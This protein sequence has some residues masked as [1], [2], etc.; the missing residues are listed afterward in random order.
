MRRSISM[1][2]VSELKNMS[3]I[4]YEEKG[5]FPKYSVVRES[6]PTKGYGASYSL[7]ADGERKGEIIDIPDGLI[8]GGA[9]VKKCTE[10]NIPKEG[11]CVGDEYVD[12]CVFH[13][14]EEGHIY[15]AVK[16]LTDSMGEVYALKE[17]THDNIVSGVKGSAEKEYRTGSVNIT[18]ADIG[19]GNV[20]NKSGSDI[21]GELTKAEVVKALGYTPPEQDTDT[22]YT[23]A[24]SLTEGL[25]S[26]ND[27]KKLDGIEAGAQK[28][29]VSGV[30]GSA[31]N[32]YRT[33]SVN[34]TAANIGLGNV[35]NKSGSDI[36][37]ELTKSEVV[38]AL[39][40]TPPE[41]DTK[42][43]V[44]GS[45]SSVSE[46]PVQN[47][48][49]SNALSDGTV[50]K[51][52]KVNVGGETQGMY[53]QGGTPK[54]G[55]AYIP[56]MGAVTQGSDWDNYNTTGIWHCSYNDKTKDTHYPPVIAWGTLVVLAYTSPSLQLY[57]SSGTYPGQPV[58]S[59][60]IGGEWGVFGRDAFLRRI[61]IAK[62]DSAEEWRSIGSGAVYCNYTIGTIPNPPS[63]WGMLLNL[64]EGA[65]DVAQL[66]IPVGPDNSSS[67][68]VRH[69][70]VSRGWDSGWKAL[71]W[72]EH[73]HGLE[74]GDITGILPISKGGTGAATTGEVRKALGIPVTD[75]GYKAGSVVN[76]PS[77]EAYGV[78][79]VF[80]KNNDVS[81]DNNIVVGSDNETADS[82]IAIFGTKNTVDYD[83]C[84]VVGEDNYSGSSYSVT[85]GKGNNVSESCNTA[86]G[87]YLYI[88]NSAYINLFGRYNLSDSTTRDDMFIV[89]NG[90]GDDA[91]SNA[92]RLGRTGSLSIMGNYNSNGA[93]YAEYFE[94]LDGN[95]ENEDR[96]GL[97][98]TL[99]GEKIRI[100][101]PSDDYILGV[102][103]AVPSIVGNTQSEVWKNRYMTDIFGAKLTETV[104]LESSE[105]DGS[106][107]KITETR[108][109]TNPEYDNTQTYIRREDRVEWSPVGML[110]M[111]VAVDDGSCE[112]NG[113][114]R[115][116][117]N[118]IAAKSEEKTKYRVMSRLDDNHVR[119]FI[120]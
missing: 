17:H 93:D 116:S 97:F 7:Y 13:N 117:E 36:R 49:I 105:K 114:C 63:Q 32:G 15:F 112:V 22:T 66:W 59:R 41:Q 30:K 98:V 12:I 4:S 84:I 95:S 31:E 102:V 103:S 108:F 64:A 42:V 72:K 94:W 55:K 35:E 33:G 85:M 21:R 96:R 24:T 25:M 6:V 3:D 45:L 104:E 110:G 54:A 78:S 89:G 82:S 115:P 88:Q 46:N 10:E 76:D 26:A 60:A 44:D 8:T 81:G 43:A 11:L 83:H 9:S 47:K 111:L 48:V 57:I 61:S 69:G 101:A 87:W 18:A 29:A 80:G 109:I 52:G 16:E 40:Y 37:G 67:M 27:K 99:E 62:T 113:Y 107:K 73:T 50:S 14:G 56:Y 71:S 92:L 75:E 106:E 5:G 120:M 100:A 91:R 74:S 51:L 77:N 28:N 19:L 119:L 53:L 34:I 68:Y 20:E 58:Y 65:Y 39:G 70:N 1:D 118:G 2:S 79:L 23:A 86:I 38:K 90:T